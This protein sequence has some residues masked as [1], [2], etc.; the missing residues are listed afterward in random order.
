MNK[1][2]IIK[3]SPTEAIRAAYLGESVYLFDL[4]DC[5]VREIRYMVIEDIMEAER[6]H[7]ILYFELVPEE[8][9]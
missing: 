3:L 6:S 1:Y 7:T 5:E 2:G 8:T 4:D 9:R